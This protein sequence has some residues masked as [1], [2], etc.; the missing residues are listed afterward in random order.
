MTK[1]EYHQLLNSDYWRG[2]SYSL[3]KERNFTC[4]D[5][6]RQFMNER[7]KLQVHHL[8]YRDINP[9]SYDPSEMVVLCRECHEK[10]HGIYNPPPNRTKPERPS[11]ENVRVSPDERLFEFNSPNPRH[12]KSKKK[13]SF[14][15]TR[16][17]KRKLLVL[18]LFV[19]ILVLILVQNGKVD[20]IENSSDEPKK[21]VVIEKSKRSGGTATSKSFSLDHNLECTFDSECTNDTEFVNDLPSDGSD[22]LNELS[23]KQTEELART[24]GVST[25]GSEDEILKRIS[26]KQTEELAR[27][28]GVSTRGSEEQIMKRISRKQTEELAR[29][30]GVSTEGSEDEIMKRISRKQDEELSKIYK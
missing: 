7:N 20:N 18:L 4:E 22:N 6:G 9:C 8:V 24:Y 14:N 16:S 5:C 30:Y 13:G 3:I 25:E 26:R 1:E 17:N 10:R 27:S 11:R 21:N 2:F 12:P 19:L 23:R 28:Y 15:L 29:S